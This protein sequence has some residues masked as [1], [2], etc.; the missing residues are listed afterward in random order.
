ML[1]VSAGQSRADYVLIAAVV[2]IVCTAAVGFLHPQT[3][4]SLSLQANGVSSGAAVQG[5]GSATLRE[6][7]PFVTDKYNSILNR[8]PDHGGY[9]AWVNL[10]DTLSATEK[11]LG[12]TADTERALLRGFF[13]SLEYNTVTG[14]PP[15][16]TLQ[17]MF[18]QCFG[19]APSEAETA[20]WL[21]IVSSNI[22]TALEGLMATPEFDARRRFSL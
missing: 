21:P 17:K 9:A 4:N 16:T 3:Q 12:T 20:H 22:T 6:A 15:A 7:G 10:Y 13:Y 2:G 8:A 14:D 11:P 18:E 1:K 5:S 19:R